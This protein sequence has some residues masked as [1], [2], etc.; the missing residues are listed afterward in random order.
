MKNKT[1][2]PVNEALETVRGTIVPAGNTNAPRSF[3]CP[4]FMLEK[5]AELVATINPAYRDPVTPVV[6][7]IDVK[8]VGIFAI[9]LFIF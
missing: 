3:P 2:P 8:F 6:A 7:L 1:G 9:F 4:S 5:E